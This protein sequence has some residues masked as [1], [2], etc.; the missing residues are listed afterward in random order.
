MIAGIEDSEIRKN[1]LCIS[2]IDSKTNKDIV[3]FVEEKEIA[4]NALQSSTSTADL[5]SYKK[6]QKAADTSAENSTNKQLGMRGKY[7]TC[8]TDMSLYKQYK[9]GKL[10][11]P[12]KTCISCYKKRRQE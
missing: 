8:G 2:D 5:F 10:N 3:K 1:V 7:D 12:F 4:R 9:S 11:G 6:S